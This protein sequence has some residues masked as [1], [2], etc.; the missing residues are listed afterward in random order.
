[1][2]VD[3]CMCTR[4]QPCQAQ[5]SALHPVQQTLQCH[6]PYQLLMLCCCCLQVVI[7][8]RDQIYMVM[9]FV[10]HDLKYVLELQTAKKAPPFS[11]GQVCP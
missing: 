8:G 9:E 3:V 6:L 1:M 5:P 10:E 11:I 4:F 2:S 7:G